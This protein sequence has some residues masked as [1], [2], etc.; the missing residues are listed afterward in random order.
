MQENE[1]GESVLLML[2]QF[3]VISCT[4]CFGNEDFVREPG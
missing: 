1:T 3:T 2:Y 4:M